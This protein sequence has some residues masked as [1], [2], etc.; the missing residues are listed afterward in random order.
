MLTITE[1]EFQYMLDELIIFIPFYL[2]GK[3]KWWRSQI[4]IETYNFDKMKDVWTCSKTTF[5]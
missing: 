3:V 4:I 5:L 1:T 2:L